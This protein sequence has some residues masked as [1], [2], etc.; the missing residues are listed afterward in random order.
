MIVVVFG[1]LFFIWYVVAT[2][3]Y[4]KFD[5][6]LALVLIG[7]SAAFPI[8][9]LVTIPAYFLGKRIER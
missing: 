5:I 2:V 1:L 6:L 3:V 8:V 9:L 7:L 4:C